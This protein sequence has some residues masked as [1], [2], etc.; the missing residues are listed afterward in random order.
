M[1]AALLIAACSSSSPDSV[2]LYTSVTQE[3]V[4]AVVE[5]YEADHADV[6]VEVFRAPTGELTA[7]IAAEL[8]EG[9]LQADVLWLTDPLSMQ[10]Y[11]ADGLLRTWRAAGAVPCPG[12]LPSFRAVW[13]L[14]S[15]RSPCW[16]S[17]G[18]GSRSSPR[19]PPRYSHSV[20]R[21][22]CWAETRTP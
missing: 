22:C 18:V 12:G 13:R 16:R 1:S 17:A 21:T 5:R 19:T 9:G 6:E 7:R 11:G 3:T 20:A 2:R 8:R 15:G 14:L 10:Q 4:D